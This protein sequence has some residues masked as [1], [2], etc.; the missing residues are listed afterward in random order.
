MQPRMF[1]DLIKF[2]V[3]GAPRVDNSKYKKNIT[4]TAV[5]TQK[6]IK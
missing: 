4:V 3:A 5:I 2:S 1:S 6:N